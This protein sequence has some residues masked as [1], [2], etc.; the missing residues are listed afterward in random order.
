MKSPE[1]KALKEILPEA[2]QKYMHMMH[3]L[4]GFS[5]S[6]EEEPEK[7]KTEKKEMLSQRKQRMNR[8]LIQATQMSYGHKKILLN[9]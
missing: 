8:T 6:T 9:K 5:E 3:W 4:E 1:T 7:K 2:G